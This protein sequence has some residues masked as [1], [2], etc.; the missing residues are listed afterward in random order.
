VTSLGRVLKPEHNLRT[1][2]EPI[3]KTLLPVPVFHSK[4]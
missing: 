2:R 4:L 1:N 3:V